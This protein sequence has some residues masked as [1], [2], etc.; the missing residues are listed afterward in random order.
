MA[1]ATNNAEALLVQARQA[2]KRAHCPYSNFHVGAAVRCEDGSVIDGCNVEN[3][4]YGLSICAER[5]ALFT[6]I[7]LG[8]RPIALA[9]S[10]IDAQTDALPNSRMPCGACR[11]VMQELL[12]SDAYVSIDGVGTMQL[13]QLLPAPFQL[14][15]PNSNR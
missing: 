10:C 15:A 3:A 8:K 5:V 9:V 12:P 13:D 1:P 11:Q 6:A 14:G 4:S 2:A 7:S